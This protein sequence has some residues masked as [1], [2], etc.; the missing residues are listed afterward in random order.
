MEQSVNC[1]F[2]YC[3]PFT[4][5]LVFIRIALKTC[6]FLMATIMIAGINICFVLF[7]FKKEKERL[8]TLPSGQPMGPSACWLL[9]TN[10]KTYT[11]CNSPI[12]SCISQWNELPRLSYW[13]TKEVKEKENS[14]SNIIK[15]SVVTWSNRDLALDNDSQHT[16]YPAFSSFC[17]ISTLC[18]RLLK[19]QIKYMML[20]GLPIQEG[21]IANGTSTPFSVVPNGKDTEW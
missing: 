16:Y 15:Y 3:F 5:H 7:F 21:Y 13:E 11:V 14:T 12:M 4:Q 20:I 6:V 2:Q 8:P 10:N 9:H 17:K 18:Y 19:S 1:L